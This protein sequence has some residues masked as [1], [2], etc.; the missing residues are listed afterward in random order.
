MLIPSTASLSLPPHPSLPN[1]MRCRGL[2]L[3]LLALGC[4][5][6]SAR[7]PVLPDP[8]P[9]SCV[10]PSPSPE[11]LLAHWARRRAQP[12]SDWSQ[13]S[14]SLL[15]VRVD[16]SD[17]PGAPFT[18]ERGSRLLEELD[19]FF[20]D[21]SSG[22]CRIRLA[23]EG[24]DFTPV[25][26]MPLPASIYGLLDPSQLRNAALAAAR[27][28]GFN[29]DSYE[30]DVICSGPISGFKFT[31]QAYVGLRGAWLN[32]AFTHVGPL[33][34]EIGHNLGLNHANL[35]DTRGAGVI[36]PGNEVEYGDSSD[37]MSLNTGAS[38]HFNARF[39]HLLGWLDDSQLAQPS[40]NGVIR[41]AAHDLN[42]SPPGPR[43]IR[44]PR[45][46]RTNYWFEFRLLHTN[47]P[48]SPASL[49]IRWADATNRP[50]LLLDTTPGSP[51]AARDAFLRPGHTFSDPLIDFHVTVLGTV[52]DPVEALEVDLQFG[53][54]P[55]NRPPVAVLLPT[56]DTVPVGTAITFNVEASDPDGDPLAFG[57]DLN[58]ES[59]L[60]NASSITRTFNTPGD[61]LVSCV[62]SDRR[63]KATSVQARVRVGDPVGFLLSGSIQHDGQPLDHV[64]V[65][66]DSG[67]VATTSSDGRYVFTGMTNGPQRQRP[68]R[69]GLLFAPAF[70]DIAVSNVTEA[71]PFT[72][73]ALSDLDVVEIVPA[74]SVWRFLDNGTDPGPAWPASAFNDS[75]WKSGPAP[76]GYGMSNLTTTVSFGPNP[77]G[78]WVTTFFRHTLSRPPSADWLALRIQL[79]RDDGA[80]VH[81]NGVEVA[82]SNMRDGAHNFLTFAL[83]DVT[84]AEQETFFPFLIDP[85]LWNDGTNTL[86]VE[87]HQFFIN[88]PDARFDLRL[89]ALR[90]PPA[91][92][93][94][95]PHLS[96]RLEDGIVRIQAVGT[97]GLDAEIETS[98]DLLLWTPGPVIRFPASGMVDLDPIVPGSAPPT[99]LFLRALPSPR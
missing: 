82:R 69:D 45:D 65:R 22:R 70:Q 51:A 7:Q 73:Y 62:V 74:G 58:D 99:P 13:G 88:S 67:R 48:T 56:P 34:H 91:P 68:Y 24:S 14:R 89:E 80:I 43:A 32:N 12:A 57:W 94:I 92:P 10:T 23:G 96:I 29:P 17:L 31:G 3:L 19:A 72:A 60:P 1:K 61:H 26:R 64:L 20:N 63:G 25:L 77:E 35:W 55:D 71:N 21:M 2:F 98:P 27:N 28:A 6:L 40:S 78:K 53:P 95:P 46:P 30:L 11:E 87:I 36:G 47:A 33:A 93:I 54:F 81:L 44:I 15:L 37:T 90:I 79:Q 16:F 86:A 52:G 4:L 8:P 5:N 41:L 18:P 9:F 85:A 38:R 66:L 97:P 42:P 39:K 50:T 76:L 83:S 49:A 84:G 75:S 59:I